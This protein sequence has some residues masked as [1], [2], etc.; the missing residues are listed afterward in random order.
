MGCLALSCCLGIVCFI[1]YTYEQAVAIETMGIVK[2]SRV[3]SRRCSHCSYR[4]EDGVCRSRR[5]YTCYD[6]IV[7]V[8][9]EYEAA[10]YSIVDTL[11]FDDN[12]VG[13]QSY[14]DRVLASESIP[15]YL[16]ASEP[17]DA[18]ISRTGVSDGWATMGAVFVLTP[19][20]CMVGLARSQSRSYAG[21]VNLHFM[22]R[23]R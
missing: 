17:E 10:S 14:V 4:D 7:S 6:A 21:P 22:S 19:L 12:Y 5:Y 15:V 23:A 2:A 1:T 18:S 11:G 13:A 9:Y 8:A 3:A 16:D 20:V